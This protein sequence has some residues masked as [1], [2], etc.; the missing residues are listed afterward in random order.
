MRD[1]GA[2]HV[3][4]DD[5]PIEARVRAI[6]SDGVDIALELVG[7]NALPETLR[8]VRVHGGACDSSP[9]S[10]S[11]LSLLHGRCDLRPLV[12]RRLPAGTALT[13]EAALIEQMLLVPNGVR[14]TSYSGGSADLNVVAL[15]ELLDDIA[16]GEFEAPIDTVYHGL[17]SVVAAH[18]RMAS[19]QALGK[20]V[21]VLD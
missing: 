5:G 12:D 8:C 10:S 3:V 20:L 7:T 9:D 4:I 17:E 11:P 14:L 13:L 21:V 16:A 1:A 2:D 18:E 15:Q 19:N 6:V